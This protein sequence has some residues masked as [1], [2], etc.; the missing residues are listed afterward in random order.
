[1]FIDDKYIYKLLQAVMERGELDT[2]AAA[3]ATGIS[4]DCVERYLEIALALG[5]VDQVV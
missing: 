5:L 2:A 3:E 4:E 1:M